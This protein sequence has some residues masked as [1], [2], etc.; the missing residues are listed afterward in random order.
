MKALSCYSIFSQEELHS[1]V[2]E[3][4]PKVPGYKGR[5]S[6][7]HFPNTLYGKH[8]TTEKSLGIHLPG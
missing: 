1:A 5:S 7:M 3:E 8:G 6:S 4:E 2:T